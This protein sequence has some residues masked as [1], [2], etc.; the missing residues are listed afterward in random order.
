VT[1][2]NAI[3]GS[4]VIEL[5]RSFR[6]SLQVVGTH[7]R[8]RFS[9]ALCDAITLPCEMTT[10]SLCFVG[11]IGESLE[12][13]E[14]YEFDVVEIFTQNASIIMQYVDGDPGIVSLED[15]VAHPLLLKYMA[16]N[17]DVISGQEA[18]EA[19]LAKACLNRIG[20][21]VEE[22]TWHRPLTGGAISLDLRY[23]C[24]NWASHLS[25][26]VRGEPSLSATLETF[27]SRHVL[28]WL[29]VLSLSGCVKNIQHCLQLA[30]TWLNVSLVYKLRKAIAW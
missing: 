23:A 26:S 28:Y 15:D 2:A 13:D 17:V 19:D 22:E 5:P 24:L 30:K 20:R 4:I 9:E 16:N 1:K 7:N 3:D 11:E 12:D 14:N 29:K 18:Q 21:G 25:R 6:G 8:I 27:L 10:F